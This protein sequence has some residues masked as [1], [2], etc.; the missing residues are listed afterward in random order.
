MFRKNVQRWSSLNS[1]VV[2]QGDSTQLDAKK[3]CELAGTGIRLFS[4]DGGHTDSIVYSDM[5]LAE[6]T[7]ASGGIVIADDIFNEQ[8][9]DV[10]VGTLRYLNQVQVNSLVPFTVGFNKVFFSSPEYA[11]YYRSI[12]RRHLEKRYLVFGRTSDFAGHE[13]LIIGRVPRR[14]RDILSRS[15]TARR[16]YHFAQDGRRH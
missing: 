4:I 12:L 10:S 16:I 11:E 5:N 1:V 14:P 6:T 2:H 7:L 3:L 15:Q 8:W 9:P 13:V